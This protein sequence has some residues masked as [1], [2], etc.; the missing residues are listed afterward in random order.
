MV[1]VVF[2]VRKKA[3]LSLVLG[4]GFLLGRLLVLQIAIRDRLLQHIEARKL[5][6]RRR[7]RFLVEALL[8]RFLRDDFGAHQI[9]ER[10]LLLLG[11]EIGDRVLTGEPLRIVVVV[12]AADGRAIDSRHRRGIIR[13]RRRRCGSR[14][15]RVRW[16]GH[17]GR[18][19]WLA[20]SQNQQQAYNNKSSVIHIDISVTYAVILK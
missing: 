13:T 3:D 6:E 18:A 20:G 17:R 15:A 16:G 2:L 1:D 10:L 8:G 11:R 7:G 19:L 14:S 12:L 9:V 4:A 5:K